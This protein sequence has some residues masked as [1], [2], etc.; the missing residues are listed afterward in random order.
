MNLV[1]TARILAIKTTV[2]ALHA[3]HDTGAA[4]VTMIAMK[5]VQ[6]HVIGTMGTVI[7]ASLRQN[8]AQNAIMTV[9]SI[10]MAPVIETLDCV[11]PV[12]CYIMET[13]V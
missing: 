9:P 12:T 7:G 1:P 6:I 8:G 3:K 13:P 2:I 5:T 10:V 11:S 4:R